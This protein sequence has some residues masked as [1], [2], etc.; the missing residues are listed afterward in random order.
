MSEGRILWMAGLDYRVAPGTVVGF[1]LAGGGTGW[2]LAQNLGSGG[3]DAFQAG[4][5]LGLDAHED[6]SGISLPL[7]WPCQHTLENLFDL[8]S[9]HDEPHSTMPNENTSETASKLR[10]LVIWAFALSNLHIER[11]AR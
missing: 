3:S 1:A 8:F 6:L 4:V 9:R 7:G 2:S 10:Y 5:V 11:A